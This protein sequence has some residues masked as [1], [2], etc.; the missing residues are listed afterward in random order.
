MVSLFSLK[1]D[2]GDII[3]LSACGLRFE[4]PFKWNS[5]KCPVKNCYDYFG[6]RA[7]AIAH[8]RKTHATRSVLCPICKRPILIRKLSD[9]HHHY[10]KVHPGKTV[11]SYFMNSPTNEKKNDK[12]DDLKSP[13]K[14][15]NKTQKFTCPLMYCPHG[16]EMD[17]AELRT[18]WKQAHNEL[19]FPQYCGERRL[20]HTDDTSNSTIDQEVIETY[21]IF[22]TV[23][24]N[25]IIRLNKF[26]PI[27]SN[28][29][30]M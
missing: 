9:F 26:M 13:A 24:R 27:C 22:S 2:E 5:K 21:I 10:K 12:H 18:H 11:P 29:R 8:Y 4:W 17:M 23:A 15:M 6:K 25:W 16:M 3:V 14:Q 7:D 1:V 19:K 20:S 28:S 30:L